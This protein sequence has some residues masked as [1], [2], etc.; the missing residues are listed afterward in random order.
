MN[1]S[2][3]G[4]PQPCRRGAEERA[5]LCFPGL[6][7][8]RP[9]VRPCGIEIGGAVKICCYCE[10]FRCSVRSARLHQRFEFARIFA[11]AGAAKTPRLTKSAVFAAVTSKS[12]R[13]F[14]RFVENSS[15][16]SRR[17]RFLPIPSR[18]RSADPW[19]LQ[20]TPHLRLRLSAP[21]PGE[22]IARDRRATEH[23]ADLSARLV[24]RRH[25]LAR[26]VGVIRE[27]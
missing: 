18:S 14:G 24:H 23:P 11:A 3:T 1:L 17:R 26:N 4:R 8:L 5:W 21:E 10:F 7:P 12:S 19:P 15:R 9:V 22:G 16:S 13:R 20:E 27:Q 6:P 2:R 25:R